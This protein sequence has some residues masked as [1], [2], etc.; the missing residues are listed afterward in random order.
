MYLEKASKQK[1]K[2]YVIH[3]YYYKQ[4]R[5]CPINMLEIETECEL[6][7]LNQLNANSFDGNGWIQS[8]KANSTWYHI[9][10]QNYAKPR[11]AQPKMTRK[12]RSIFEYCVQCVVML[13]DDHMEKIP[14]KLNW[15]KMMMNIL[16]YCV[17]DD[18]KD[19][20]AA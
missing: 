18:M 11:N 16:K 15:Y 4:I 2:Y 17:A 14:N 5:H 1:I 3:Y 12:N 19:E 20:T 13:M 7:H 10:L 9:A 6:Y 8:I